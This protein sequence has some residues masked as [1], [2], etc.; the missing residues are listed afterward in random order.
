MLLGSNY[1]DDMWLGLKAQLFC[2]KECKYR[3][4]VRMTP[5]W[6]YLVSSTSAL[7]L[8]FLSSAPFASP[9]FGLT[10]PLFLVYSSHV[11]LSL[12]DNSSP[13][14]SCHLQNAMRH[15]HF[16]DGGVMLFRWRTIWKMHFMAV[17]NGCLK[18]PNGM[19]HTCECIPWKVEAEVVGLRFEAGLSCV[20][21]YRE[22]WGG[23]LGAEIIKPQDRIF[24][25]L[26]F[27][28][29]GESAPLRDCS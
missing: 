21:L 27:N 19:D 25:N 16:R 7:M 17:I 22:R 10:F 3:I 8:A 12:S 2:L 20:R 14:T 9:L 1:L 24:S 5:P 26:Q 28:K 11:L 29:K 23:G 4:R 18:V 6:Y 13:L 15:C